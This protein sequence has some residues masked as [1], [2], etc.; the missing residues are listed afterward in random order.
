[1]K[2]LLTDNARLF[3]AGYFVLASCSL[4]FALEKSSERTNG[5]V[6]AG[7]GA[8]EKRL[9]NTTK[10]S[11]FKLRCVKLDFVDMKNRRSQR[12]EGGVAVGWGG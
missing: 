4:L 6:A 1:M 10:G 7:G 12:R 2:E 3:K 11:R 9:L 5:L 8:E